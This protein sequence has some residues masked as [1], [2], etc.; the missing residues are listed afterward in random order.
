AP[1]HRA[2]DDGARRLPPAAPV[3]YLGGGL[4]LPDRT[5]GGR[6]LRTRSPPPPAPRDPVRDV[7][8]D[9]ASDLHRAGRQGRLARRLLDVLGE[10]IPRAR[11]NTGPP[12]AQDDA[13]LGP[14][15]VRRLSFLL[16]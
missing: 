14:R 11:P 13:D 10:P 6:A 16:H 7:R 15:L 2:V 12:S 8:G 9:P 4:A 3:L 1:R 5:V